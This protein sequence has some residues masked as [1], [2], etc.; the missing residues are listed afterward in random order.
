MQQPVEKKQRGKTDLLQCL[1]ICPPNSMQDSSLL[2][3]PA[4]RLW[5]T[6]LGTGW[7]PRMAP[8]FKSVRVKRGGKLYFLPPTAYKSPNKDRSGH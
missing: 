5:Q 8:T 6:S 1:V 7:A 3:I 2:F 4:K